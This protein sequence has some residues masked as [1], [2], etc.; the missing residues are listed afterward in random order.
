ML[1]IGTLYSS[2]FTPLVYASNMHVPATSLLLQ[3]HR[4]LQPNANKRDL[5]FVLTVS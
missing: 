1:Q 3:R 4:N 5:S 2:W